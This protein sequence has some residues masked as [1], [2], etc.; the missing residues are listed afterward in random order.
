M[1]RTDYLLSIAHSLAACQLLEL[2]LKLYIGRALEVV[3]KKSKGVVPFRF[4]AEDYDD[5]SLERL[6]TVFKKLNGNDPLI[7][8]LEKFRKNRNF[9]AHRAFTDCLDS[10]GNV[11]D[12]KVLDTQKLLSN[13][14]VDARV[15]S[16][17]VFK[18]SNQ[19]L[20]QYYFDDELIK[21]DTRANSG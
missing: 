6:I 8:R 5:S 12:S 19:F 4:S 1:E 3:K 9:V 18:E 14:S 7:G 15:L 21:S 20:G 13:V 10:E 2:E 16:N 11:I 17:L